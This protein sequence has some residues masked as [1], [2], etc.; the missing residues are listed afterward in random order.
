MFNDSVRFKLF[1]SIFL[2]Q[3]KIVSEVIQIG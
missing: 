1:Q 3:K 2:E